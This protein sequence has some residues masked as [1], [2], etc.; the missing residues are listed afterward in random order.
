[1]IDQCGAWEEYMHRSITLQGYHSGRNID[2]DQL[3][4]PT[5]LPFAQILM[6]L[7]VFVSLLQRRFEELQVVHDRTLAELAETKAMAEELLSMLETKE[8]QQAVRPSQK[9]TLG[10]QGD[11]L[12]VYREMEQ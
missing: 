8:G 2:V 6:S 1:M 4:T 9:S 10:V 5:C 12:W 3:V 11:A 7:S